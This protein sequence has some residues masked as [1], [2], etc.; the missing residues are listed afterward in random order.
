MTDRTDRQSCRPRRL[1]AG[2]RLPRGSRPD[3]G[4]LVRVLGDFALAEEAVQDAVVAALEHWPVEGIPARP[5][6]WLFT[7]ARRRALDSLRRAGRY[8]EKLTQMDWHAVQETDERLRLVFTCCHPALSREAQIALTL[9]AVCGLTT[10]RYRPRLRDVRG[11]DRQ[12]NR[13]GTTQN[14]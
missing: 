6:A 14:R 13:T 10:A 9:R 12:A 5:G 3:H 1:G 11:D 2:R 7:V 4:W 8:R